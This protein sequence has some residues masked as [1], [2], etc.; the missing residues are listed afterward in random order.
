[1]KSKEELQAESIKIVKGFDEA[2]LEKG[3][4]MVILAMT[5]AVVFKSNGVSQHEAINR[6]ATIVKNVYGGAP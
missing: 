2:K 4:G 5:L 6:F 3:E 1:M